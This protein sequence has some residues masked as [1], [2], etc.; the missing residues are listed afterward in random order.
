MR[1]TISPQVRYTNTQEAFSISEALYACVF[2]LIYC[3]R[4]VLTTTQE[5]LSMAL[6]AK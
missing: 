6:G 3:I 1:L 4:S 5:I 2:G